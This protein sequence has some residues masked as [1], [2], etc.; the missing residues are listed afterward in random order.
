MSYRDLLPEEHEALEAF[1]DAFGRRW[2][3]TLGNT[4][5]Y[6]ARVWEGGR[7]GMGSTLHRIRNDFGPAWLWDIYKPRKS[8]KPRKKD[9]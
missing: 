7:P 4:Y 2:R 5:W 1:A 9:A 8:Y 6:N 3:D